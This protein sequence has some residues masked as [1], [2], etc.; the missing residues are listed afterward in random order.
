MHDF[1]NTQSLKQL[2]SQKQEA[3]WWCLVLRAG[4]GDLLFNTYRVS[5]LQDEVF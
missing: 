3:K 1:T 2:N 5:V 4:G